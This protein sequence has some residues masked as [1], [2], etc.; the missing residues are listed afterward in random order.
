MLAHGV[1][2]GYGLTSLVVC[3]NDKFSDIR[4]SDNKEWDLNHEH[5]FPRVSGNRR[6]CDIM[7]ID[8]TKFKVYQ[9]CKNA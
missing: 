9:L 5:L 4:E 8:I 3:I 1:M 7:D 2:W 6:V